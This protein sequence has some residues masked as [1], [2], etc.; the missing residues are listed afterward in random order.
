MNTYKAIWT[1]FIPISCHGVAF[2]QERGRYF[3]VNSNDYKKII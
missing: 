1:G 2:I 3:R